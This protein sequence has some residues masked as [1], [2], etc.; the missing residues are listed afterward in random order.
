[1]SPWVA[2]S[3]GV[4]A[5]PGVAVSPGVAAPLRHPTDA[6][7][8]DVGGLEIDQ[9]E[10]ADVAHLLQ[11]GEIVILLLRPSMLFVPLASLAGLMLIAVITL[12]LAWMSSISWVAWTDM[13]AFTLGAG[14]A[15][16]R[17]GWQGL[18]WL[19]R[20]YI[21]TDRRVIRRMG[22]LRVSLFEAQ[23]RHIQHTAVFTRLRE[24]LLGLGS[25][26]F[27]TAGSDVF[28][29]LWLTVKK[30]FDVHRTVV[31]TLERYGGK[32]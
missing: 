26:G 31:K 1:M 24:R 8:V 19:S 14:A 29:A 23:L 7:G 30:P 12:F 16:L 4:A 5:S 3:P 32:G 6:S 22:V 17:L 13:Q 9:A 20:L 15:I 18:D 10:V 27:S 25:I 2:V 28:D 11:D 21:L